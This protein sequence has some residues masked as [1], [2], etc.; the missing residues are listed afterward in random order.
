MAVLQADDPLGLDGDGVIMGDQNHSVSRPVEALEQMQDLPA[1]VGVQRA[2]GLVG[3]D[4]RR[5]SHQ[6]PG[7]GDPLLLSA[8]ELVWPVPQLAAQAHQL[9]GDPDPLVPLSSRDPGVHHGRLHILQQGELWEQVVLLK[10]KAQQFIADLRQLVPVY[11]AHVPAIQQIGPGGGHIQTAD[12]VHAGGFAGPGLARNCHK[13]APL[14][15][16]GNVVLRPGG[17]GGNPQ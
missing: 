6:R 9:Q 5:F 10:D 14:D 12:D 8:G 15:P 16:H 1:G 13:F 4:D 2:G 7:D 3:E 17:A 11:S